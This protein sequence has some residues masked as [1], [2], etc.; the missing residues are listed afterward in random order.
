MKE[1][2]GFFSKTKISLPI[3]SIVV[4]KLRPVTNS[5]TTRLSSKT[6]N[7]IVTNP[8]MIY[9][10]G[11]KL[12]LSDNK[13]SEISL[14]VYDYETELLS[15]S[16]LE[17]LVNSTIK[18]ETD[19]K[20]MGAGVNYIKQLNA[21]YEKFTEDNR[22]N[23]THIS[24]YMALFQLWNAA[25]FMRSFHVIRGEVMLLSKIGSKTWRIAC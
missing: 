11:A 5:S 4:G 8:P 14:M 15:N 1:N 19:F 17:A 22:L 23:P 3:K 6:P 7:T 10:S 12:N 24:L 13:L 18:L 25:H 9:Q 20:R 21:T 16:Y 2:V